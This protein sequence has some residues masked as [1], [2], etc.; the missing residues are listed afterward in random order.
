M[1]YGAIFI[2]AFLVFCVWCAGVWIE[3]R[4]R[5][6]NNIQFQKWPWFSCIGLTALICFFEGSYF[7]RPMVMNNPE[8]CRVSQTARWETTKFSNEYNSNKEFVLVYGGRENNEN[9][10][11]K[12]AYLNWTGDEPAGFRDIDFS[13][14]SY[15]SGDACDP[16]EESLTFEVLRTRISNSGLED[17]EVN[18]L[19]AYI[20]ESLNTVQEKGIV[21][22]PG[23]VT[24]KIWFAILDYKDILIGGILWCLVVVG[25]FIIANQILITFEIRHLKR[26]AE[27]IAG[28]GA[29]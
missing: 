10:T 12:W 29:E 22:A 7:V 14:L 20:W 5:K 6:K 25:V 28:E 8:W 17:K 4:L 15:T 24:E 16:I 3:K 18:T 9:H 19:S 1:S 27:Q 21:T 26:K 23:G 13:P 2:Y 11:F